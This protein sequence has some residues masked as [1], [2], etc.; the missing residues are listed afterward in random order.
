MKYQAYLTQSLEVLYNQVFIGEFDNEDEA[1]KAA[2]AAHKERG[3][4]VEPYT[5]GLLYPDATYYDVGSYAH[6]IAILRA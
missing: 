6:F 3:Y 2:Y 5:R 4:H 1:F